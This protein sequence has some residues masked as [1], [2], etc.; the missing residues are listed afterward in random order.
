MP[1][2]AADAPMVQTQN[3]EDEVPE[4]TMRQIAV[5]ISSQLRPCWKIPATSNYAP[6]QAEINIDLQGYVKF[7]EFAGEISPDQKDLAQS[8]E[9]A[10]AD[11][12]CNPIKKTPPP[13]LYDVWQNLTLLF[14]PKN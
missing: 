1:A 13:Q 3:E 12:N 6:L 9:D 10:I 8:V 2:M 4:K 11:P 5:L 7:I 14:S